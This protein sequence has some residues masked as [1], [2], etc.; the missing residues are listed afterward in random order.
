MRIFFAEN[1]TYMQRKIM[2]VLFAACSMGLWTACTKD[3]TITIQ[4]YTVPA[5]YDFSNSEYTEASGRVSM[6]AGITNYLGKSTTRQLSADTANFL[7]NN[8]NSAFTSETVTNIPFSPAELNGLTFNV[9]AKSADAAVFKKL[10][11]S[12]VNVSQYYKN[13]GSAGIPGKIGTRLF[14][15]SGLEFNQV[16]AK[17][18]M[19]ALVLNQI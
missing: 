7:W 4:P 15:H 18:L 5:S 11:D 2:M 14:N 19:G 8:T 13:N 16:V 1:L 17:G 10:I 3:D 6:W 9:A 12:M